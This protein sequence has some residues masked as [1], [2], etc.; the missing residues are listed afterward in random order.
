MH[1]A[2]KAKQHTRMFCGPLSDKRGG[3]EKVGSARLHFCNCVIQ[4]AFNV[5]NLLWNEISTGDK[6][7]G[8]S[9]SKPLA[10]TWLFDLF[11]NIRCSNGTS[12]FELPNAR[13]LRKPGFF[14]FI[15]ANEGIDASIWII[16]TE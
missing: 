11:Q 1:R 15:R 5:I 16:Y 12:S 14:D 3:K 9:I 10:H 2:I 6:A 7:I 13:S 4:P 8:T